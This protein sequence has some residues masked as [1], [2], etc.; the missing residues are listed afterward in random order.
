MTFAFT[1]IFLLRAARA[2][3]A[4]SPNAALVVTQHERS[5]DEVGERCVVVLAK[6]CFQEREDSL[7]GRRGRRDG[8]H[9]PSCLAPRRH[10]G[11]DVLCVRQKVS[12]AAVKA[13]TSR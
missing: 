7:R 13:L 5:L 6:H 8:E 9:D 11:A 2:Y 10:L 1:V 3:M 4:H 12:T